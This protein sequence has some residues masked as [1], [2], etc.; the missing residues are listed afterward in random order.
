MKAVFPLEAAKRQVDSSKHVGVV[1]EIHGMAPNP[2]KETVLEA[3]KQVYDPEMPVDVVN[4]GL[5]YEVDIDGGRDSLRDGERGPDPG[6]AK[7]APT[8]I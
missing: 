3:L 4:L 7:G 6:R 8:G 5:I 1:A 2:N